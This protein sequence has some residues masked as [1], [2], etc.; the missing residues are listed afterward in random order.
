MMI[1]LDCQRTFADDE[2]ATWQEDRGEFWGQRAY[3]TMWGCPYCSG[4]AVEDYDEWLKE[5]EAEEDDE[6]EDDDDS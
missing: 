5:Q 1:C 3:E 2:L 4:T 6:G